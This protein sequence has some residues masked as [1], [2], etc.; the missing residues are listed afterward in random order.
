MEPNKRILVVFF[1]TPAGNEPV[2]QWLKDM[3]M[4]DKKQ[5]GEDLK[6]S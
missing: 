2:R 1:R 4:G 6:T 5:I 3:P